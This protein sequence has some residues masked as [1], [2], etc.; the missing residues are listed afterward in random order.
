MPEKVGG[1]NG[2]ALVPGLELAERL[3]RK[4][5]PGGTIRSSSGGGCA[6]DSASVGLSDG[7]TVFF[8]ILMVAD[9]QLLGDDRICVRPLE[10]SS[11]G[12]SATSVSGVFTTCG[13]AQ[14][15][16]PRRVMGRTEV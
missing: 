12:I 3:P 11:G 10:K 1:G 13:I 15:F 14:L 4:M 7:S 6:C 2:E 5:G 9:V 8:S 16:L